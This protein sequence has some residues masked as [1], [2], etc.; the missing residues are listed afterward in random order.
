MKEE[1]RFARVA[2]I[3]EGEGSFI[4]KKGTNSVVISCQMTDLDVLEEIRNVL[5]GSLYET[6]KREVHHKQAWAWQLCGEPAERAMEDLL[7]LMFSRRAESIKNA[8]AGISASRSER[9]AENRKRVALYLE[10]AGEY[11]R[12][13]VTIREL[14][15]KYGVSQ[16]TLTKY[17][18]IRRSGE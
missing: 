9:E 16:K 13:G 11:L 5:G 4:R 14:K 1:V 18:A 15:A 8:M 3:L 2:G 10:I 12:G 7:P 6:S 17:I